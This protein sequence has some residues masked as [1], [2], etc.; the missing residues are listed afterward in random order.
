M[1]R[2][3]GRARGSWLAADAADF[4]LQ[5]LRASVASAGG[6]LECG[7]KRGLVTAAAQVRKPFSP[8]FVV[9]SRLF[10]V[11]ITFCFSICFLLF[12]LG[13]NIGGFP[14]A[15]PLAKLLSAD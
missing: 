5:F 9:S 6:I 12:K 8:S 14:T 3:A 2:T 13:R 15:W 1:K 11:A 10:K 4:G 7:L